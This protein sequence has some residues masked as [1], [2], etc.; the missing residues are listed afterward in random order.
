MKILSNVRKISYEKEKRIVEN[1]P[2]GAVWRR[3][4]RIYSFCLGAEHWHGPRNAGQAAAHGGHSIHPAWENI[5]NG[6]LPGAVR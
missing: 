5:G 1:I 2:K 4:H 3:N 6:H